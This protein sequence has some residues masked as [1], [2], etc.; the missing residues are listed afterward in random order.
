MARLQ[1][2]G[3]TLLCMAHWINRY[4]PELIDEIEAGRLKV[5]P[6]YHRAR[7]ALIMRLVRKSQEGT[8]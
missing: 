7:I 5:T 8:R 4:A 2:I 1:G 3:R 6:A